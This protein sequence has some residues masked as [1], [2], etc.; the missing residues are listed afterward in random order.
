MHTKTNKTSQA[1]T[2]AS[3]TIGQVRQD[4]DLGDA[5]DAAALSERLAARLA[6]LPAE[7][8]HLLRRRLALAAHDLEGLVET[9]ENELGLLAAD[10]KALN[11]RTGAAR[12]Y[13][14]AA[15]IIPLRRA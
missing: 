12:A 13:G 11:N 15:T 8:R 10:L 5:T 7:D 14:H 1:E 2:A 9:L 4:L 3:R 6:G